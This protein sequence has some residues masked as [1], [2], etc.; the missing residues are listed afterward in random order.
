MSISEIGA[1]QYSWLENPMDQGAWWDYNPWGRKESD[2][3]ERLV[4][5]CVQ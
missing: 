3:T 5:V 4:C 1:L 2:T